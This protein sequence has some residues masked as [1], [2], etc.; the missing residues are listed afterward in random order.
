MQRRRRTLQALIVFVTLSVALYRTGSAACARAIQLLGRDLISIN[1]PPGLLIL[2]K[3]ELEHGEHEIRRVNG[4]RV[5][6]IIQDGGL[7]YEM[8][9]HSTDY[10]CIN[11]IEGVST[12]QQGVRKVL[13][14]LPPE[15]D[16]YKFYFE[17]QDND[18]TAGAIMK[19]IH[20]Q[21]VY[22]RCR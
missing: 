16:Q 3:S 11:G 22:R 6:R 9:N 18:R 7:G 4:A 8:V 1:V 2:R 10:Y 13:L 21:G 19:S 12:L 20:V 17:F 14:H 5:M 15:A